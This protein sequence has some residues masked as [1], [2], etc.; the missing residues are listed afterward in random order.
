MKIAIYHN[1][2]SGGA[3]RS[4]YE[5]VKR[6]HERH[7]IIV[8]SLSSADHD[9][10]D[11]RPFVKTHETYHFQ[12]GR[13]FRSPFGR[14]NSIVRVFD[15]F[16]LRRVNKIIAREI[17]QQKPD[18]VF[19]EPCRYE[20]A[21]SL[22]RFL[23]GI[24]NVYYCHE[25]FR[26]HYEQPPPRPYY[27]VNSTLR[28]TIDQ[29]DFIL[30]LYK[31]LAKR[32]DL[33][34]IRSA[35]VVFVNSGYTKNLV[36]SI[37]H[38][39]AEINYLGVDIEKFKPLP[40]LT[41]ANMILSVGSLT[42]LKGFDFVIRSISLIPPD[43]R[44]TLTISS[45]FSNPEEYKYLSNVASNLGVSVEFLSGIP[46]DKLVELYNQATLTAY[47]PHREPF[48]LVALESMACATPVV[49]VKE[50]GL[51]E[52]IQEGVNGRLVERNEQIFSSAL[53]ELLSN[54]RKSREFGEKGYQT[55]LEK[56]GW[57]TAVSN[58]ESKFI[59]SIEKKDHPQ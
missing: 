42:P 34:N 56:W 11:I 13:L 59:Q 28:K 37:Y 55:V 22:L 14:F 9:F 4:L 44:P 52:T 45:N 32:N 33:L 6:L 41:K 19:V 39:D 18:L 43:R 46:D 51:L 17:T 38:L 2:S 7:E 58:L 26:V 57:E 54:P 21:P 3:K 30:Y 23:D 15:L 31:E 29:I 25:P 36:K 8:F 20:N 35:G 16:R 50:G 53:F 27:K 49:G 40:H 1:L 48:G 47:A 10:C 5:I 12:P 24:P